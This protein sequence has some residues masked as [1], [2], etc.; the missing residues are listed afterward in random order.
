MSERL[1]SLRERISAI[2]GQILK[3]LAERA[4]VAKEIGKVKREQGKPV[5]DRKREKE[6]YER[7]KFYAEGLGLN[8]GDCEKIFREIVRLCRRVQYEL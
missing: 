2:D 5:V 1:D 8:P 3:L 7:V 6:V 4:A